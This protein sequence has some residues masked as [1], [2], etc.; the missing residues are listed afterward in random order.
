[1]NVGQPERTYKVLVKPAYAIRHS[2]MDSNQVSLVCSTV[3][4]VIH[5]RDMY[6]LPVSLHD[7]YPAVPER[8][9]RGAIH[10]EQLE[11]P[12]LKYVSV[13]RPCFSLLT[14]DHDNV[15]FEEEPAFIGKL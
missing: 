10:G 8:R 3:S 13:L 11:K 9:D 1:M 14:Q 4:C 12:T 5:L 6:P 15:V 2:I 7:D